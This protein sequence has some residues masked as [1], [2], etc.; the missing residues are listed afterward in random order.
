MF[1]YYED[2]GYSE[3]QHPEIDDLITETIDKIK[4]TIMLEIKD[5]IDKQLHKAEIKQQEIDK[6]NESLRDRNNMIA[7]LRNQ[8]KSLQA[9]IDK[10]RTEIPTFEYELGEEVWVAKSVGILELH[11]DVCNGTGRITITHDDYGDLK[12]TCPK[13][14]SRTYFR[15]GKY[16]EKVSY[17]KYA[18]QKYSIKEIHLDY[19]P[20]GMKVSYTFN[21]LNVDNLVF[22]DKEEC[23]RYCDVLNKKC[24]DEAERRLKGIEDIH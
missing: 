24:L 18:P 4:E 9:D 6:L 13:C 12:I 22:K 17:Y 3:A 21:D 7:E 2:Y 15:K 19:L 10:K 16:M 11:C 5:E 14:E 1:S 23:I 20:K 8:V